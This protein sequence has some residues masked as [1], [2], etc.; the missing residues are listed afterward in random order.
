MAMSIVPKT[1]C[2]LSMAITIPQKLSIPM[3]VNTIAHVWQAPPIFLKYRG[4]N[5]VIA[6]YDVIVTKRKP[7][8]YFFLRYLP[9]HIPVI[10]GVRQSKLPFKE[11]F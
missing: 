3:V 7:H 10:G 11:F 1:L 9:D 5:D 2:Q 4:N 6:V 8:Q